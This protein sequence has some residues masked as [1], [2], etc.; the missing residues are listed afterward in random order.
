[1]LNEILLWKDW[2]EITAD[3]LPG[4]KNLSPKATGLSEVNKCTDNNENSFMCEYHIKYIRSV[5]FVSS[6]GLI[7]FFYTVFQLCLVW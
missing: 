1:M 2:I 6:P 3:Y 4:N 5:D 7:Y